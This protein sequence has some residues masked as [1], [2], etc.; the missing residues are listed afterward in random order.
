MYIYIIRRKDIVQNKIKWM[1]KTH[2]TRRNYELYVGIGTRY[3]TE[4]PQT[5][6]NVPT[7]SISCNKSAS[8]H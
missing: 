6:H 5:K 8:D 2:V 7:D 3:E 4:L 1:I